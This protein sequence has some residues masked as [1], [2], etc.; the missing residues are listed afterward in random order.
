[1]KKVQGK[2]ISSLAVYTVCTKL[3]YAALN[4][5]LFLAKIQNH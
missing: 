4:L 5:E 3:T 1:M 2:T